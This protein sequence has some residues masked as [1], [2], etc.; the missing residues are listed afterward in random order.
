MSSKSVKEKYTTFSVFMCDD[1]VFVFDLDKYEVTRE[2]DW[3]NV[4]RLDDSVM[5]CFQVTN[6]MRV[7]FEDVEGKKKLAMVKPLIQ[8]PD[9]AA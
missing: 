3:I 1:T 5:E 7:K 4:A 2:D 8:P 9:P 6:V